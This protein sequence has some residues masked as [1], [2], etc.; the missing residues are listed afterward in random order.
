VDYVIPVPKISL[1]EI[2]T[3]QDK[4]GTVDR[5]RIDVEN[6]KG[7]VDGL[8]VKI[9]KPYMP[10]CEDAKPVQKAEPF[11]RL[12]T[13]LFDE[14]NKRFDTPCSQASNSQNQF[15]F[16]FFFH[17]KTT[18]LPKSAYLLLTDS[19]TGKQYK[20]NLISLPTS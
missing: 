8:F 14:N 9:A 5:I 6:W 19:K 10:G 11:F 16:Q 20:S 12:V 2:E 3:L 7:Y 1:G 13:Q 17:L 15:R 18:A 4:D